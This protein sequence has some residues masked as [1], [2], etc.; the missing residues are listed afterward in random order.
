MPNLQQALRELPSVESLTKQLVASCTLPRALVTSFV[1][2]ELNHTRKTILEGASP[3]REDVQRDIATRL[4]EFSAS[5]LQPVINATGVVIHTN[6][7]R[8]PLG[9]QAAEKLTQIATGYCNLEFNLP[10][11]TRGKRAGYLETALASLLEAESATAVNNCAAALVLTL[12]H[13]C[14]EGKNEVIVSRGELVEI[15]GGFRIPDILETSGAKLVEVGA[16]NKTHLG[17]YEK[18]ITSETAMILKVHRS[19][20][21]MG[22]FTEEP[23]TVELAELAHS[24]DLPLIEDIGSGAMMNTDDLAP[25]DHE[26]R[27]QDALKNGID[28]VCFSGDKLLGGPQSGIIAGKK[29]LVEGIKK[30]P[31]FR[32][33]RCDKLILTVLQECIDTYLHTR[34]KKGTRGVPALDFISESTEILHKRAE[35]IMANLPKELRAS[36]KLTSSIARTGG[37]TMPKSEIPSVAISITSESVSITKLA[38]LLRTGA[39][40]IVGTVIEGKLHLDLRTVFEYQDAQLTDALITALS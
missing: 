31:F 12:R 3:S 37:G 27:P 7:G 16:T 13:L 14:E 6:L 23:T 38:R 4:D 24:H 40:A 20:F 34:S 29:E 17:D 10:E 11:G 32:A 15:G 8:S 30:E 22:G 18:A 5:R 35:S 26:P 36:F 21:Y 39:P 28:L 2:R 1:Q 9:V 19:N 25:I 33:V